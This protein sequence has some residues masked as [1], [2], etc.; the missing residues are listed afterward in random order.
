MNR[1]AAIA[2][3][4]LM[5]M[6]GSGTA[7]VA[8]DAPIL[9]GDI[10]VRP[11][12]RFAVGSDENR[13]GPLTFIGGLEMTSR[14]R[15]FGALS[16]IR[17]TDDGTHF[18]G[19]ADTGFWYR[20][21]LERDAEGLPV[22]IAGFQMRAI[23]DISGSYSN[24][25]RETDAEGIAIGSDGALT[26]SFER[27]HRISIYAPAGAGF[28]PRF[29]G[30]VDFI[31]PRW[32]LRQNRG[33]ETVAHAPA[34]SALAGA[35]VAISEKSIDKAG[36]IFAA[37][38][39]GP[40]KGIFKVARTDSYD[41]TDGDFL[42]NGD[43]LILERRFSMAESIGMRIRRILGDQIRAGA[44]V[45]GAVLLEADLLYQIDNMEGLD[46]WQNDVGEIFV[47]LVSDDN[48]SLLQRNLYLEFMLSQ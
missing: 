3:A 34:A 43:L 18:I 21:R 47:S 46:V 6:A 35:R 10:R 29:K 40:R 48:H 19:V 12:T 41:I 39:E 33:F 27:E 37:V 31:V 25:K 16:G 44:T 14:L 15:H 7:V 42:P 9:E 11:I 36:N 38:L 24:S 8:N 22:G 4:A 17:F 32:E 23:P 2:L 20:G 1:W 26:V 30:N 45:D 13:F 28:D 5:G